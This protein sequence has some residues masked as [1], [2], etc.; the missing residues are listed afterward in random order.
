MAALEASVKEAREAR[1]RHPTGAEEDGAEA[2]VAEAKPKKKPA[3]RAA[4]K[5]A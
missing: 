1:K 5:S 2:E 4:K 3:K